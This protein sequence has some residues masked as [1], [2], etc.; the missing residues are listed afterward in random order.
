MVSIEVRDASV[1]FPVFDAK[2][3]SLKKRVL[4]K[5]GGQIDA[6]AKT[7]VIEALRDIT[8][9]LS[10]GDRV[11]LVGHNGAGK[12]TLLRL[13]SGIYEPTRGSARVTG[14]IAPVF[15]LGVGLDPEVS[16]VENIMIRGLFLGMTRKQM[17]RRVDD[18][19]E[20]T[21]LGDY[22]SLPLRTYS[23]GMRVRLA[24]GVVT[25]IDPEILILDEG[26]GAID[27]AF[28]AKARGRLVDLARRAG[29]LVFASHSDEL[30]RELCTSALW[31]DEG[32]IR[33]HGPLEDVL[34]A[35][36]RR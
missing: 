17:A 4:G 34:A 15:D 25:T 36:H 27:A 2:T 8:L 7:P 32:R 31:L 16:G 22:L 10:E 12:S 35:Y 6:D 24:L 1:D 3:R 19:A 5:V 20:F 30:L 11:G 14:R 13:L 33:D 18:I 28:L 9:S 29:A 21:E 23:A 26:L